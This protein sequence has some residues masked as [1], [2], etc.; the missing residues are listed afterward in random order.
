MI[1][2]KI[3]L[4]IIG[5][6]I[7]YLIGYAFVCFITLLYLYM[8]GGSCA[9]DLINHDYPFGVRVWGFVARLYGI[10]F[11]FVSDFI[12]EHFLKDSNMSYTNSDD[13]YLN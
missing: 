5:F 2:V 10:P 6:I 8:F 4:L 3:F 13:D 11:V 1:F 7:L 9:S 12:E